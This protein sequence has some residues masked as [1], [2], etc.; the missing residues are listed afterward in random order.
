MPPKSEKQV[1]QQLDK[2]L[3][4]SEK[5]HRVVDIITSVFCRCFADVA[6]PKLSLF[7]MEVLCSVSFTNYYRP[8]PRMHTQAFHSR[9]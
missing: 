3:E 5:V 4:K 8:E 6:P 1:R 7:G 9:G 2:K